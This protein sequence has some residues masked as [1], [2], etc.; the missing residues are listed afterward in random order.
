M[1]ETFHS[2]MKRQGEDDTRDFAAKRMHGHLFSCL[3]PECEGDALSAPS[4]CGTKPLLL[5]ER[6]MPWKSTPVQ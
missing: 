2:K 3:F 1:D 5:P 4:A 6:R